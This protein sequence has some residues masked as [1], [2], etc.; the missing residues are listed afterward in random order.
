M[1]GRRGYELRISPVTEL[2]VDDNQF[3]A[4]FVENNNNIPANAKVNFRIRIVAEGLWVLIPSIIV[5][6]SVRPYIE[7]EK[8]LVFVILFVYVG[9]STHFNSV[10]Y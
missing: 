10:S 2:D 7:L 3:S 1:I 8:F 4:A 9:C 6:T 5:E